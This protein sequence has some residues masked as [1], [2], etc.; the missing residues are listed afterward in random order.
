MASDLRRY[1]LSL[2]DYSDPSSVSSPLPSLYADLAT[3]RASNRASFEASVAWWKDV[4]FGACFKGA[5]VAGPSTGNESKR[6]ADR[7]VLHVGPKLLEDVSIDE[8]GRPL[9]L[10][11]VVEEL[12]ASSHLHALSGFLK[13]QT[14][15]RGPSSSSISY[16]S[17]AGTLGSLATRPLSWAFSQLTLS[18]GLTNDG[19]E[20][21]GREDWKRA[22]G[23]WVIWDNVEV[24]WF[25]ICSP[26][27]VC[28]RSE[29]SLPCELLPISKTLGEAVLAAHRASPRLSPL[30]SLFSTSSFRRSVLSDA[31]ESLGLPSK[32]LSDV[33]LRVLLTH[34]ARDRSVAL[35]HGDVVKLEHVQG[36]PPSPISEHE[37][38][39]VNVRETH[40]RLE[41]QV[42][43]IESRIKE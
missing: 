12:R 41:E 33:D 15:V 19:S 22:Q 9:G 38:G 18:L 20:D 24:G 10:G 26:Y 6:S 21:A 27:R 16:A 25:S 11:T 14:P 39:I 17:V 23:D 37:R 1:V 32:S 30:E 43:E 35:V 2:P 8:V 13:S 31:L 40:A 36:E 4:L 42:A 3:R 5:Q 7:L 34:L 28:V 29:E